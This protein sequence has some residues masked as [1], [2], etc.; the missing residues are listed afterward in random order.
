MN[1]LAYS[2]YF[3]VC[4]ISIVMPE[5]TQKRM[6]NLNIHFCFIGPYA[7]YTLIGNKLL[8]GKGIGAAQY[9]KDLI[10]LEQILHTKTELK[11]KNEIK[12]E[13]QRK[14]RQRRR[15]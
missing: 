9:R 14:E 12:K 7:A 8:H 5:R 15:G 4:A 1:H 10:N 3:I 2:L 13:T 6:G 11:S